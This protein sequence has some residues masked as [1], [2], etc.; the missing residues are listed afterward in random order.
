[1]VTKRYR[2]SFEYLRTIILRNSLSYLSTLSYFILVQA[3]CAQH[4]GGLPHVQIYAV[5]KQT[6]SRDMTR[7]IAFDLADRRQPPKNIS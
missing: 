7:Y 5:N 2:K 3:F 4:F 6:R 1:M